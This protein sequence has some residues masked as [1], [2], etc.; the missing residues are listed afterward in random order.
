MIDNET[1]KRSS[2]ASFTGPDK[3]NKHLFYMRF[4]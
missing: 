3:S 1:Q 4:Y 2:L